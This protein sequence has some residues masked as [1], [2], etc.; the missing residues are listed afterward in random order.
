VLTILCARLTTAYH[1]IRRLD[2]DS[3]GSG[4][5]HMK[6][7]NVLCEDPGNSMITVFKFTVFKLK[8]LRA[9]SLFLAQLSL[10]S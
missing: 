7:I 10:R 8:T 3:L 2:I 6:L 1:P 4:P 9:S 5:M